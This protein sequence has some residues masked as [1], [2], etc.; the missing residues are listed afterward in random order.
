MIIGARQTIPGRAHYGR[1]F[2]FL[3]SRRSS[4]FR[5]VRFRSVGRLLSAH[6]MT[7]T[8]RRVFVVGFIGAPG[9]VLLSLLSRGGVVGVGLY[10]RPIMI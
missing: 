10:S 5:S 2:N 1:I 4:R 7:L 3:S 8:L 9:A 6:G